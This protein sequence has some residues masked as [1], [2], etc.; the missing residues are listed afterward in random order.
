MKISIEGLSLIKKFEGLELEAYKCAA[1]VWTIGYGHIKDVKEGDKISKAEADEML[2]HEIEEYEN[3]VNTA[4][5]VPLSQNQFDAIVSWV[6]NLGNG[7]LR[8]STMLKVINAGDH[9]GVPAQIKR[10]NKAGGKVLEGL[11]R[12][13][14]AEALLYEGKEW[15][16]V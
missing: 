4:V 5:N 7:N 6:F 1:G 15:S 16:H 9:A 12:R 11:I 13:R 2:V 14:E 3:Y 8:A 10:W